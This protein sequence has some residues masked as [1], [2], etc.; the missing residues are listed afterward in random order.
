M[1]IWIIGILLFIGW[2]TFSA[3]HYVCQIKELCDEK[4]VE[5]SATEKESTAEIIDT[6]ESAPTIE[7]IRFASPYVGFHNGTDRII[8]TAEIAGAAYQLRDISAER[9]VRI[10]LEGHTDNTGST[11]LNYSLGLKRAEALKKYLILNGVNGSII[12]TKSYGE[13]RPKVLNNTPENRAKNRRV[14]IILHQTN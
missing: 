9:N 8:E 3:Y 7:K 11:E 13:S 10:S 1:R 4:L 14:E 12:E 6:A 5:A 2:A